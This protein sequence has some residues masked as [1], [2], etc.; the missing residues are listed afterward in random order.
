MRPFDAGAR[1]FGPRAGS[2]IPCFF[3]VINRLHRYRKGVASPELHRRRV[4]GWQ[5]TTSWM[6]AGRS[7]T[8]DGPRGASGSL[9]CPTPCD[10]GSEGHEGAARWVDLRV[11][12][13]RGGDTA[14]GDRLAP[15]RRTPRRASPSGAFWL[16]IPEN[17]HL[18]YRFGL[19]KTVDN[20]RAWR[21]VAAKGNL[22]VFFGGIA[23]RTAAATAMVRR[24]GVLVVAQRRVPRLF[25]P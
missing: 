15:I 18:R 5:V 8:D 17:T 16:K 12:A 7:G 25:S 1:L 19:R 6:V 24:F 21:R 3:F 2:P 4:T 11:W 13:L 10:E 9:P 23:P 22:R 20:G 14:A